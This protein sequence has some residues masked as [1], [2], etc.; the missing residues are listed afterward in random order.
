MK[1]C[2][3]EWKTRFCGECGKMLRD[4][5]PIHA[6]LKH[7]RKTAKTMRTEANKHGGAGAYAAKTEAWAA[8]WESWT[9]AL[10]ELIENHA[11]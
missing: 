9:T 6:L 11:D 3:K 2:G 7:C 10:A 5:S 1:C 8:K 4:D